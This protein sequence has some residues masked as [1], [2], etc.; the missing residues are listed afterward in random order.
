[1]EQMSL[2]SCSPRLP[3]KKQAESLL[4]FAGL[5]VLIIRRPGE[6]ALYVRLSSA[7]KVRLLCSPRIGIKEI[8]A[9]LTR[10]KSWIQK[11]I[12]EQEKL[13]KKY[14]IKTFR[15]GEVFLFQGK[16]LK[17]RYEKALA[18]ACAGFF[19]EKPY[20]LYRYFDLKDLSHHVLHKR[21]RDFYKYWGIELLQNA[22]NKFSAR[23]RL[24]PKSLR[25]GCPKSLWGSCSE[26][27]AISLNWRLSTAPLE[28]LE[29]VVIHELAHLRHLN[30]SKSFWSLVSRFCPEYKKQEAWLKNE[31]YAMDFLL[32]HP[33]LHTE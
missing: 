21:L 15:A 9:F 19:C 14:P 12:L 31:G 16:K 32:F 13:R 20:L 30:H 7:G 27:G 11:Q 5:R 8:K 25:I 18:K 22:L 6:K 10:H 24:F 17:L 28:V 26:K 3:G 4:L 33:E 29:Y 2:F 1:M 23:M